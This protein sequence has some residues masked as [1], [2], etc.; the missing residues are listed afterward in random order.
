MISC[1]R[2]V[3]GYL[4]SNPARAANDKADL[5]FARTHYVVSDADCQRIEDLVRVFRLGI[6]L[7][8]LSRHHDVLD[9]KQENRQST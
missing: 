8:R 5:P 1:F 3:K 4:T 9:S 7:T 6:V 2:E